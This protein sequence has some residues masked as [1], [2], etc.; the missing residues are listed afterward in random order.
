[1][2]PFLRRTDRGRLAPIGWVAEAVGVWAGREVEVVFDSDRH[3]IVIARNHLGDA[4]RVT[5]AGEGYRR[6]AS[7]GLQELWL[8]IR[9]EPP[10]APAEAQVIPLRPRPAVPAFEPP[11]LGSDQWLQRT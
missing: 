1:V 4:N 2:R 3:D 8:R 6:I 9:P 11:A 5:L 10:A 7:D